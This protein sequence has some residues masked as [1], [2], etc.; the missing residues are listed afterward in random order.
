MINLHFLFLMHCGLIKLYNY[1]AIVTVQ[2]FGLQSHLCPCDTQITIRNYQYYSVSPHVQVLVKS[3][4]LTKIYLV[5]MSHT[6][7]REGLT[8]TSSS[9]LCGRSGHLVTV[10]A[11]SPYTFFSTAVNKQASSYHKINKKSAC[12]SY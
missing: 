5:V 7:L 9:K 4:A 6:H 1:Y 12:P 8:A 2:Y 11:G 3:V 10:Q